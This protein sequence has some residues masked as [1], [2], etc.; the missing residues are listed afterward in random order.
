MLIRCLGTWSLLARAIH[1]SVISNW[2]K[3]CGLNA[4][5]Y[6]GTVF[7]ETSPSLA[8]SRR[9]YS[10]IS[11]LWTKRHKGIGFLG[12]WGGGL[13]GE[14]EGRERSASVNIL[15][16]CFIKSNPATKYS[17]QIRSTQNNENIQ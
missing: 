10:E 17:L 15:I 7:K 11:D 2:K 12:S 6:D 3:Y 4:K 8:S 5:K 13:M 14:E 16:S 9:P 1:T